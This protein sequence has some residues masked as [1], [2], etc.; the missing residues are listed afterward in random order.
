MCLEDA[1]DWPKSAK[2]GLGEGGGDNMIICPSVA[3]MSHRLR[4]GLIKFGRENIFF[5]IAYY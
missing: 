1:L 4:K 2:T 3:Q 5:I